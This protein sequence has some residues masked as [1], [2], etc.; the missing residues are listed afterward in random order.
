MKKSAFII[1]GL[2]IANQAFATGISGNSATCDSGALGSE[3]GS[4]A[5]R[6]NYEPE[7]IGLRWYDENNNLLTVNSASNSCT[8]GGTIT[9]PNP[10]TKTGYKF[11][12]WKVINIFSTLDTSID[13]SWDATHARW[14]PINGSDGWTMTRVLGTENSSDLSNGEWSDT[15][16][17]GTVI[18]NA[19]CSTTN[20]THATAG[21]PAN[22]GG[23]YCWCMATG[24]Q[25][26][27]SDVVYSPNSPLSWVFRYDGESGFA[28]ASNCAG[29]CAYDVLGYSTFRQALFGQSN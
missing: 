9:I 25:P 15:F 20:G 29:G 12:G 28:C 10:P 3:D 23:R 11:T 2:L 24:Y 13:T 17:Y 4:V 26:N 18:G 5:M 8:Y 19:M 21:T 1:T 6:A 22:D 7:S 14:K 27:G 16:S